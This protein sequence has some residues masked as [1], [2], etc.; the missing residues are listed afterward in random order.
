MC[1]AL[2]TVALILAACSSP[3]VLAPPRVDLDGY[4]TIGIVVFSSNSTGGLND[5]ATRNFLQ[6]VQAGQPGVRVLELGEESRVLSAIKHES[7]DFE[8]M[9]AIGKKWGVN[10]VFAGH[11]D[12]TDVKP[13]VQLRRMITSMSVRADVKAML[14]ARLVETKSGATVWTRGASAQA[15]V[16]HV[17][18]VKRGPVVFG[19]T[20][21]EEAYGKLVHT[22]V[23][24]VT[25][26][27]WSH[28]QKQ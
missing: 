10:A 25:A 18:I 13:S 15:P 24:R 6:S 3:K 28:W 27:F 26:D 1:S 2:A 14:S 20:D 12:V 5:Y 4:G 17:S 9:R 19:A 8:A 7:L 21:P 16:A 23:N 22:L 11:L